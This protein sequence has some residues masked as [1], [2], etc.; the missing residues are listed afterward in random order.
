MAKNYVKGGPHFWVSAMLYK[1]GNLSTNGLWDEY[2]RDRTKR[3]DCYGQMS[4]QL[5]LIPSKTFLKT[6][7]LAQ[8]EAQGKIR[9]TRSVDIPK[10]KNSGWQLIAPKAFRNIDPELLS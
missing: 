8:M 6:R 7:I 4:S 2:Q 3:F 10:F 5:D 1:Q 9:K